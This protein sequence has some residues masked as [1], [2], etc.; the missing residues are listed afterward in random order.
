MLAEG[1]AVIGR[2]DHASVSSSWPSAFSL[3]SMRPNWSSAFLVM[4]R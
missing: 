2:D 4:N 1:L 3:S